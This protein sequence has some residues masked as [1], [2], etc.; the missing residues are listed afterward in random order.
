MAFENFVT[1]ITVDIEKAFY[2]LNDMFLTEVLKKFSFEE[3]FIE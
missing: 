3:K 2:S 1:L